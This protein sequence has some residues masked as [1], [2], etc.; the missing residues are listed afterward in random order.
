MITKTDIEKKL[1]ETERLFEKT[2]RTEEKNALRERA[3]WLW[4]SLESEVPGNMIEKAVSF[5]KKTGGK[6]GLNPNDFPET[7]PRAQPQ[8]TKPPGTSPASAASSVKPISL[9]DEYW[10]EVQPGQT[11]WGML[12]CQF[13]TPGGFDDKRVADIF[14]K[15]PPAS[16]AHLIDAVEIHMQ[17]I[18]E[19]EHREHAKDPS[20]ISSP[21][22]GISDIHETFETAKKINVGPILKDEENLLRLVLQSKDTAALKQ[23]IVLKNSKQM[24]EWLK[25][26]P[27]EPLTEEKVDEVLYS[28]QPTRTEAEEKQSEELNRLIRKVT[29]GD[30]LIPEEEKQLTLSLPLYEKRIR[31]R[32]ALSSSEYVHVRHVKVGDLLDA[33]PVDRKKIT[34]MAESAVRQ[35]LLDVPLEEFWKRI[36][37]VEHIRAY[38]FGREL[39]TI[40]I[41]SFFRGLVEIK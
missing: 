34:I 3:Y 7:S 29:Q 2:A 12:F 9:F 20:K 36:R 14:K 35:T 19:D 30:I 1:E 22:F 13:G 28:I 40:S 16:Q 31:D 10:V 8:E 26:H 38:I 37:L 33:V 15:L 4:Q 25:Y 17:S 32:L 11:L 18:I 5:W 6:T 39:R 24:Q 23:E 41:R 27:S 21:I